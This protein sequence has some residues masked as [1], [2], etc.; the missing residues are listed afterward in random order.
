[1]KKVVLGLIVLVTVLVLQACGG[2]PS[3]MYE[4]ILDESFEEFLVMG[5]SADFEPFEYL[6]TVDGKTVAVGIDIEIAKEIAKK[7]GKNLRV[8]NKNFDFLIEDLNKGRV[9]FVMAGLTITENRAKKVNFSEFYYEAE[10]VLV[11]RK[12]DK[13]KYNSIESID[14]KGNKIGT[15]TGTVQ[16]D[17][18]NENFKNATSQFIPNMLNVL[19]DLKTNKLTGAVLDKPVAEAYIKN[20]PELTIS[21]AVFPVKED[22]F[23]IAVNKKSNDLLASINEVIVDL[24]DSG[25]LDEIFKQ[26]L[27]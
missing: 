19:N 15:Q 4:Y 7:E 18:I 8:I 24:K 14:I 10:D 23:A 9:D 16:V 6:D 1:M 11:I 26:F 27:S 17:S 25:K 3:N 13:D 22:K 20:F 12:E 21:D 2:T 5:T